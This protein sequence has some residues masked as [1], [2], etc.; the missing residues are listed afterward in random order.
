MYD[1]DSSTDDL[2][3]GCVFKA[4]ILYAK[5]TL[6][7]QRAR[8]HR[9]AVLPSCSRGHI[10]EF[11]RNLSRNED[12][13]RRDTGGGDSMERAGFNSQSGSV[14]DRTGFEDTDPLLPH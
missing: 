14:L 1:Y 9:G 10:R 13:Y 3:S 4:N 11:W 7:A 6:R 2:A 8:A 5:K 12:E